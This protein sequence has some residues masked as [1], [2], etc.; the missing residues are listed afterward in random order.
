M[1][2]MSLSQIE[3]NV[4]KISPTIRLHLDMRR[5]VDHMLSHVCDTHSWLKQQGER[6]RE[7]ETERDRDRDRDRETERQR[8]IE[9]E[10]GS[11]CFPIL[12]ENKYAPCTLFIIKIITP[13]GRQT[14]IELRICRKRNIVTFTYRSTTSYINMLRKQ[15]HLRNHMQKQKQRCVSNLQQ[16]NPLFSGIQNSARERN[17]L[18]HL[19]KSVYLWQYYCLKYYN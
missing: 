14:D 3:R 15:S 9:I 5:T 8:E 1:I 4:T 13:Q 17:C 2:E 12:T 7:R 6:E 11:C 10:R 18:R 19:E 16:I